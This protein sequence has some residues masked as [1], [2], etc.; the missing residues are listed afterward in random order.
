MMRSKLEVDN[1][2]CIGLLEVKAVPLVSH[3]ICTRPPVSVAKGG[4]VK[5]VMWKSL[6]CKCGVT[7]M[8]EPSSL[9]KTGVTGGCRLNSFP[10]L[11]FALLLPLPGLLGLKR[12]LNLKSISRRLRITSTAGKQPPDPISRF[13]PPLPAWAADGETILQIKP[14]NKPFYL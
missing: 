10:S 13:P 5:K 3:C 6:T 7:C 14:H 12:C 11:L 2:Y 9:R 8:A 1:A 4:N